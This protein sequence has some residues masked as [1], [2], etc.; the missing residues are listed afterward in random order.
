MKGENF[1][2]KNKL[3]QHK[4]CQHNKVN[5]YGCSIGRDFRKCFI[6]KKK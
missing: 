6:Y 1:Y 4:K 5:G 3:C 2:F